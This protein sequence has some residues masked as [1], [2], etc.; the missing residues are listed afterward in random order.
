[1]KKTLRE[2]IYR[3]VWRGLGKI[4][5]IKVEDGYTTIIVKPGEDLKQ[6]SRETQAKFASQA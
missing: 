2:I 5:N 4:Y 1:M 3:G 6:R